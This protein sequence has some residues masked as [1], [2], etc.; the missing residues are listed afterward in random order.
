MTTAKVKSLS[1]D[2]SLLTGD[3]IDYVQFT[4]LIS[5][6]HGNPVPNAVV[7]WRYSFGHLSASKTPTSAQGIANTSLKVLI[8]VR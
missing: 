1:A 4:A 3:G 6:A 7:Q 8:K 2:K 5:D